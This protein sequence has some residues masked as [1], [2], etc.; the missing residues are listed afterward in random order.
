MID[1]ELMKA[2]GFSEISDF[3]LRQ[4]ICVVCDLCSKSS[5]IKL[6][7]THKRKFKGNQL[8]WLCKTCCNKLPEN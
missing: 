7:S 5:I 6:R 4:V 1:W 8:E 2:R 3:K